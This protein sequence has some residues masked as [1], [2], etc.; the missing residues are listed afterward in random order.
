MGRLDAPLR[1]AAQKVLGAFGQDVTIRTV[2]GTAY[3]VTTRTMTPTTADV[4]V[5]GRLDNYRDRELLGTIRAGD[6]KLTIAA[7]DVSAIPTV[8]DKVVIASTVWD[9]IDVLP[10]Q[11]TDQA[12]LYVLQLRR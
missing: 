4:T 12:A 2:T 7:A 9:I 3:N 5:A 8:A 1:K 6:R 10:E 11:A